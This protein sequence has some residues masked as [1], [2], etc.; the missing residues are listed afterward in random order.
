[1]P[2]IRQVAALPV[3]KTQDGSLE[4]L[5]V[6]SRDTGR[7]VLPKG[8]PSRRLKD[9]DAAAREAKQEA[10]VVGKISSKPIGNYRYRKLEGQSSH[11]VEVSVYILRVQKEKRRW[12]E[13]TERERRWFPVAVA[14]RCV[15]ERKLRLLLKD[16]GPVEGPSK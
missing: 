14:A 15:R 1:M 9:K 5:L 4:V 6:T 8:W 12:R 7:W 16:L 3:R 2:T 11:L 13:Q 10:G